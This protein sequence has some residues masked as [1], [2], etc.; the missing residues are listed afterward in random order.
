MAFVRKKEDFTC[1]HCS[2]AVIGNGYTNHCPECLYSKHVDVDPGD[3]LAEC[4]GMM[5]ATHIVYERGE[6]VLTHRCETC[7]HTKRN[8]TTTGDNMDVA[9]AIALSKKPTDTPTE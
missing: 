4:G 8:K 7:G 2:K 9:A 3:R 5:K 6:W 1:E